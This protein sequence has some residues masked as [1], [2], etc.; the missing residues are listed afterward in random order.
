VYAPHDDG[1]QVGALPLQPV[2]WQLRV[3][4]PV[5]LWPGLQA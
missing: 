1:V 5:R 4:L 2:A 3:A